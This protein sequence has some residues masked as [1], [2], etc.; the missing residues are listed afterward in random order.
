MFAEG[1]DGTFSAEHH[2]F[3]RPTCSP[4]ELLDNPGAAQAAAY[5]VVLNGYELGGGSLRIHDQNM[6]KAVFDVL[7][8]DEEGQEKFG[9]LVGSTS[10]RLSASWR[11]CSGSRSLGYVDD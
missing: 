3:T 2:P 9:F 11:H 7:K 6:Q 5:D 10:V 1:R 8:M 4:Q